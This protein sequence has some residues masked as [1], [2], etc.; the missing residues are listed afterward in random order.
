MAEKRKHD[1]DLIPPLSPSNMKPTITSTPIKTKAKTHARST[2]I[3]TVNNKTTNN[4][5]TTST[6]TTTLAKT[7]SLNPP[8]PTSLRNLQL[9]LKYTPKPNPPATITSNSYASNIL[10]THYV[11]T[12]ISKNKPTNTVTT[13]AV[14]PI[15][16]STTMSITSTTNITAPSTSTSSIKHPKQAI[17]STSTHTSTAQNTTAIPLIKPDP[18]DTLHPLKRKVGITTREEVD[19][20]SRD[21]KAQGIIRIS[22]HRANAYSTQEMA[23]IMKQLGVV[24]VINSECTDRLVI[25]LAKTTNLQNIDPNHNPLNRTLDMDEDVFPLFDQGTQVTH[26]LLNIYKDQCTQTESIVK[27][28]CGI[29]TSEFDILERTQELELALAPVFNIPELVEHKSLITTIV[30][31]NNVFFNKDAFKNFTQLQIPESVAI[32][33]A[34]GPKFSLP[35]YYKEKDFTNLREAAFALNEKFGK[36]RDQSEVKEIILNHVKNYSDQQF[37]QHASE[38]RDYFTAAIGETLAFIKNNP[39][40]IVTQADKANAAILMDRDTYIAKTEKLLSDKTTYAK[41]KASSIAAYQKMN[42]ILIG[43]FEKAKL[44][45]GVAAHKAIRNETETANIYSLIKTHKQGQPPRPIVNTINTPG[46]LL[47]TKVTEILTKAR[48][49]IKYNV[50]NATQAT[51]R[52]KNSIILPDEEFDSLDARSMFT[53]ISTKK[54]IEAVKKR[55]AALSINHEIMYL[56]T[57]AIEFICIKSTE[58]SFNGQ[59]YKQIKGLRMGSSISPILADFVMEDLLD[60]LFKKVKKPSVIIKYVDDIMIATTPAHAD[61]ILEAINEEDPDLKFDIERQGEDRRINY[62]DFTIINDPFDLKTKWFQ[63]PIASGRFLNFHS[64]HPK[65]VIFNTAVAYVVTMIQNSSPTFYNE[66]ILKAKHLLKINSY[67]HKYIENVITRTLEKVAIKTLTPESLTQTNTTQ[68]KE[69]KM[70]VGSLPNIPRLTQPVSNTVELAAKE[71]IS[72]AARPQKTMSQQVY[73]RHK[74]IKTSEEMETVDITQE[75]PD[76]QTE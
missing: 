39:D 20:Y 23:H 45:S 37:E 52:I 67:P 7:R 73:N 66:I 19:K 18:L 53:N 2:N 55:Q 29:Q 10:N 72:L 24:K 54:A 30:R 22:I 31:P 27:I 38:I 65:T 46:Y 43:K 41:L 12:K 49:E 14:T 50:F 25:A 75:N 26:N 69:S 36:P 34:F 32:T 35:V 70:Y 64:H 8:N 4:S 62:L 74:R 13:I 28:E 51:E 16:T 44:I 56:I 3:S 59:L 42:Q 5:I 61:Q 40:I 47:A 57:E 68:Q 63:K 17:P 33:L 71:D 6:L 9:P 21:L 76:N 58:I 48:D 11:S 1:E 60:N 15:N